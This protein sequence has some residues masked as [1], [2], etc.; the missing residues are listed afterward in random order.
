M[1]LLNITKQLRLS[2]ICDWFAPHVRRLCD[3]RKNHSKIFIGQVF[4]PKRWTL[5]SLEFHLAGIPALWDFHLSLSLFLFILFILFILFVSSLLPY[6]FSLSSFYSSPLPS[7]SIPVP[8]P[9]LTVHVRLVD[10]FQSGSYV[11]APDAS[12]GRWP[13]CNCMQIDTIKQQIKPWRDPRREGE[14]RVNIYI[15]IYI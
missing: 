9:V 12:P 14:K 1:C 6:S 5:V 13:R 8:S 7:F 2:G 11:H 3:D 4:V 10:M 15:Y